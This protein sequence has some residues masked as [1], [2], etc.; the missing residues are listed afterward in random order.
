M[1]TVTLTLDELA[2]VWDTQTTGTVKPHSDTRPLMFMDDPIALSCASYRKSV[3]TDLA[4]RFTEL[5]SVTATDEDYEQAESIRKYYADRIMLRTLTN[6]KPLT[7][8]Y[9]DLYELIT[10]S[11]EMQRRHEGMI[12]RLPYFYAEDMAREELENYFSNTT[13]LNRWL[14]VD[15]ETHTLVPVSKIFRSRRSGEVYEYWFRNECDEPVLWSISS[16][17]DLR[18]IVEDVWTQ[19]KITVQALFSVGQVRGQSFYHYYISR[20][21]LPTA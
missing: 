13:V 11:V 18:S 4:V 6:N 1:K 8:F 20:P 7:A 2:T 19:P 9:R 21:G 10:R 15:K 3:E 5:S 17:T 16:N 12:Y 14:T